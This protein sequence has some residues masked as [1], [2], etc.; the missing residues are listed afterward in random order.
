[1]FCNFR[2]PY[3]LNL[4]NF[5]ITELIDKKFNLC[6]YIYI[7]FFFFLAATISIDF[8][9]T[10]IFYIQWC[11][12]RLTWFGFFISNHV[13]TLVDTTSLRLN[14][15]LAHLVPHCVQQNMTINVLF[16]YTPLF[17]LSYTVCLLKVMNNIAFRPK[18]SDALT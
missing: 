4:F 6:E 5:H 8:T 10:S 1:M 16:S 7:Y 3:I 11:Q 9:F 15:S 13:H 2:M 14:S 12:W 18:P 17:S